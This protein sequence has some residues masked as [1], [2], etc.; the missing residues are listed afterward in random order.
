MAPQAVQ[1][2]QR[3][4]ERCGPGAASRAAPPAQTKP[5]PQPAGR[6]GRW[7]IPP[8]TAEPRGWGWLQNCTL[9]GQMKQKNQSHSARKKRTKSRV[10]PLGS[11]PCLELGGKPRSAPRLLLPPGC[12]GMGTRRGERRRQQS[13]KPQVLSPEPSPVPCWPGAGAVTQRGGGN[14]HLPAHAGL[15]QM[16]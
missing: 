8:D 2:M 4:Q 10:L 16:G 15:L 7:K 14:I 5:S 3:R 11:V 13:R 1:V 6:T 9:A 12:T